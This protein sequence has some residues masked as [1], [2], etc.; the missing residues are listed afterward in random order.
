MQIKNKRSKIKN[1]EFQIYRSKDGNHNSLIYNNI[2]EAGQPSLWA[3]AKL[4]V[5]LFW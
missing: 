2:I 1:L 3:E 4:I 5:S